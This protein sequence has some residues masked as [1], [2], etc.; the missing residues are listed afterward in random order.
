LTA[1][2]CLAQPGSAANSGARIVVVVARDRVDGGGITNFDEPPHPEATIATATPARNRTGRL[3]IESA[4][5]PI[6][7]PAASADR[8]LCTPLETLSGRP[9]IARAAVPMGSQHRR[10]VAVRKIW[11][12]QPRDVTR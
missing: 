1:R 10:C 8:Q 12:A 4:Y 7:R 11:A 9:S 2:S 5:C 6:A 3:I